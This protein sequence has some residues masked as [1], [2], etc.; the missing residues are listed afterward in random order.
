MTAFTVAQY[1]AALP[2]IGAP[3]SA[4]CARRSMRTCRTDNRRLWRSLL[5]GGFR[6]DPDL[7]REGDEARVVLVGAQEGIVQQL[8]HTWV[9]RGPAVLQPLEHFVRFLAQCIYLSDLAGGLV[10]V[11]VD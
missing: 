7:L 8:D 2:R 5:G 4:P 3:R 11:F 10:G 9:V 6:H 1:L